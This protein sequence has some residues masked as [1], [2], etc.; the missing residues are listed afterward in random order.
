VFDV[1]GVGVLVAERAGGASGTPAAAAARAESDLVHPAADPS[2]WSCR[3]L[4]FGA[5]FVCKLGGTPAS[6]LKVGDDAGCVAAAV[7]RTFLDVKDQVLVLGFG[8]CSC[9]GIYWWDLAR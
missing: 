7:A 4:V 6:S 5:F 9:S 3:C 2:G 1:V 8:I